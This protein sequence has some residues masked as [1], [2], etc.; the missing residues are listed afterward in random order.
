MYANNK[1]LLHLISL[2]KQF[3]IRKIVV[4]PGSRHMLF[5]HSIEQD[6]YFELYSVVDERSAAFFAIGLIQQSHEPVAV[7]CTSGTA[8]QNFGS[9]VVEAFY[10]KLPLLV[11]SGDR[12]DAYINQNEDQLYDQV[13]SFQHCTKYAA[14]LPYIQ[15]EVDEWHCNRLINEALNELTIHGAGPVHISF[16]IVDHFNVQFNVKELPIVRKINW[17]AHY[18]SADQWTD[19]ADHLRGKK[20]AIVWGQSVNMTESLMQSVDEFCQTFDAVILTDK[21]SNCNSP[22]AIKKTWVALRYMNP[23]DKQQLLPDVVIKIGGTNF[24]NME[25]KTNL[26][27]HTVEHWQVGNASKVCDEFHCLTNLFEMDEAYFFQCVT[28]NAN[29]ETVGNY[30][31][32]WKQ[33]LSQIDSP[34]L[35]QYNELYA[36]GKL[37]TQLP[38]NVS[39]QLANSMTIRFSEFFDVNTS[40]SVNCNR[41]TSGIDG[42]LSTAVG[43]ASV[44][45]KP[46]FYITGE[47]SFFYDMNALSIKH[48]SKKMRIMLINN[49][50]GS[51]LWHGKD[52]MCDDS[53]SICLAAGNQV[54]AK[55]WVESRGFK[56][57]SAHNKEEVDRG[58]AQLLD[59]SLEEPVF[60][61]VFTEFVSDYEA[62]NEY[63]WTEASKRINVNKPSVQKR[64]KKKITKTIKSILPKEKVEAIKILLK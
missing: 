4:C 48:L 8:C 32:S 30:F 17:H 7:T 10:Q 37:L 59:L 20:V 56:Y 43:Y 53:Y 27:N 2:L 55:R 3:N 49:S 41:A 13:K 51:V 12:L 39:L 29:F 28:D 9:A 61:E 23:D 60:L 22:Y 1:M 18:H 6:D 16:P 11:L 24:F 45:D 44:E 52:S 50:G 58:V 64:L 42:N 21:I 31:E 33:I 14:K 5:V 38:N 26:I 62:M 35:E 47:L 54:E 57:L 19:I 46:L 15:S 34:K 36:I 63:L 25:L 40:I